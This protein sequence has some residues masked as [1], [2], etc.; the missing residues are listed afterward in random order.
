MIDISKGI[1]N[2]VVKGDLET[3][4]DVSSYHATTHKD[5][6]EESKFNLKKRDD[7]LG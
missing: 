1:Q 6:T 2:I 7:A 5:G 3:V 4:V